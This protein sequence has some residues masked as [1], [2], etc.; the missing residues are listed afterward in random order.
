MS[1]YATDEITLARDV[2]PALGEGMSCLA[3]HFFSGHALW[4]KGAQTGAD[5]LGRVR[6]NVRLDVD[7]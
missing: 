4:R 2:V 7:R 1:Q 6:Q 3:D 5:L